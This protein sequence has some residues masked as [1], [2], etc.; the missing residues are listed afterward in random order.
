MEE[1]GMRGMGG[2]RRCSAFFSI[3]SIRVGWSKSAKIKRCWSPGKKMWDKGARKGW[4]SNRDV[5]P[6][7]ASPQ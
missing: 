6:S 4:V 1:F 2:E 7:S 3:F 5:L